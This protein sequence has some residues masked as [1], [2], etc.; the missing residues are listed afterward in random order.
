MS[1]PLVSNTR[2]RQLLCA[3]LFVIALF[4]LAYSAGESARANFESCAQAAC[5]RIGSFNIELLGSNRKRGGQ[6]IP[7]RTDE[8]LTEL[9]ELISDIAK[10]DVVSLQEI[11]TDS[12][13][14]SK[15]ADALDR[16][17]YST[18]VQGTHSARN[19]FVVLLYKRDSVTLVPGSAVEIDTPVSYNE[20]G[21]CSYDGLR[22]PVAARFKAEEFDFMVAAVHLKSK[23]AR[24]I[25][26]WCPDAI[27]ERQTLDLLSALS[28]ISTESGESDII[29]V[30]D[31]NANFNE[32]SLEPLR[33]AGYHSQMLYRSD[34][35]GRYSYR[36]GSES[37]IDHVM[38]N[39]S[40][41]G[42][43]VRRSGFV[44][45]V[46]G[47]ALRRHVRHLS[48]HM[49]VWSLFYTGADDD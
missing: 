21:G 28:E 48:D 1:P 18:A 38:I 24:G 10:F 13:Q 40:I 41:T 11:N 19:Q 3:S 37:L 39:P 17:G 29:L 26:T 6:R 33:D 7:I 23:S 25:P 32:D 35:S 47:D 8:E 14:W 31:F 27:R 22:K 42:E 16:K 9:A 34:G 49:P 4:A 12:D 45:R 20:G 44:Y 30:G 46:E 2:Q 43:F 5:L 15:L 36:K